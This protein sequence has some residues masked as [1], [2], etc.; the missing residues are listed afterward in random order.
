MFISFVLLGFRYYTCGLFWICLLG[1]LV[2]CGCRSVIR[3][4][5]RVCLCSVYIIICLFMKVAIVCNSIIFRS[6]IIALFTFAGG[7]GINCF[8]F[9]ISWCTLIFI[10]C[11]LLTKPVIIL[12]FGIFIGIFSIFGWANDRCVVRTFY[13]RNRQIAHIVNKSS[14]KVHHALNI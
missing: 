11:R 8:V 3:G 13:I 9:I 1:I 4:F 6:F 5:I 7:F 2:I 12:F 14:L 10:L